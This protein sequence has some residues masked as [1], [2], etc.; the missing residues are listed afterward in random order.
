MSKTVSIS[1]TDHTQ[2]S[3]GAVYTLVE[4]G[5]YECPSCGQAYPIVK[6]LQ[7]HLGDKLLFVF[8]NFPLEQHEFAQAAA[9]TA[10]FAAAHGKFWEMHDLL[11]KRQSSFSREL[12]PK[13]AGELGLDPKELTEALE[14]GK[15]T[16]R[17]EADLKSGQ[18]AG[19]QGTPSFYVNGKPFDGSYDYD[20]LV[21]ALEGQ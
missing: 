3:A 7:K 10:E 20:S 11:Y 2:G 15:Y 8:R 16:A 19:V 17:V 13:L 18:K 1:E 12:F 9:E 14:A 4:Y 5:D 6:K 21:A